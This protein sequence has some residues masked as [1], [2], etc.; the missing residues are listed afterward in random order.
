MHDPGY[1]IKFCQISYY[2]VTSSNN[3]LTS[4]LQI[5]TQMELFFPPII[6]CENDKITSKTESWPALLL[7]AIL[8]EQAR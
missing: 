3:T 2:I 7:P 8:S 4:T 6:W 1:Q 5:A